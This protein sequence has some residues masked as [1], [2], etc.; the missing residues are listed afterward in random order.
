MQP[1][2]TFH[3]TTYICGQSRVEIEEYSVAYFNRIA[4][5]KAP[6]RWT[7]V[8]GGAHNYVLR[9][10]IRYSCIYEVHMSPTLSRSSAI[11]HFKHSNAIE[12]CDG[13]PF[14]FYT[15]LPHVWFHILWLH[16]NMVDLYWL[17]HSTTSLG[18]DKASH[19]TGC[20]FDM[21]QTDFP[22]RAYF[23]MLLWRHIDAQN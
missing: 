20:H 13:I 5:F 23:R 15:G 17:V 6:H 7:S 19:S 21:A 1:P 11:R 3:M 12:I 22:R 8:Q 14:D 9:K 2:T 4:M 18:T 10:F 16:Q